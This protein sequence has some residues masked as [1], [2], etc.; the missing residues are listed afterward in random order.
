MLELLYTFSFLMLKYNY[1]FNIFLNFF[2][3]N[4]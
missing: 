3:S 1:M 4:G 2:Q